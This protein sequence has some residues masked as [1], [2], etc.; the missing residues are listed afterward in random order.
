MVVRDDQRR[1]CRNGARQPDAFGRVDD[2][3][4]VEGKLDDGEEHEK[5][6]RGDTF[7]TL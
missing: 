3:V 4:E 5:E 7:V 2:V 1:Q 6:G